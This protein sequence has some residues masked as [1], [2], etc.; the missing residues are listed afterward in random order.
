MFALVNVNA[1]VK[2][3]QH[4]PQQAPRV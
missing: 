3:S 1:N 4:R 2:Q